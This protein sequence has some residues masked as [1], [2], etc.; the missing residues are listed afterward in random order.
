MFVL[1]LFQLQV[2]ETLLKLTSKKENLLDYVTEKTGDAPPSGMAESWGLD[3]FSNLCLVLVASPQTG[4]PPPGGQRP[5]AAPGFLPV[6]WQLQQQEKGSF[7]MVVV[8][9]T[10]PSS[11]VH[12]GL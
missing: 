9:V 3:V 11:C 5:Q 10:E 4:S 6:A 2:T 7:V 8:I 1:G 12:F